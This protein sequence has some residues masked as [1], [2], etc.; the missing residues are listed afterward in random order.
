ME[1]R[2]AKI[3]SSIAMDGVARVGINELDKSHL[4]ENDESAGSICR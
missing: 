4:L 3:R 2:S 1:G